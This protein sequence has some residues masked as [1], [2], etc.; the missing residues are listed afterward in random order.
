M[1]KSTP[2]DVPVE[3][4]FA[5]CNY[6]LVQIKKYKSAFPFLNPVDPKRDGVLNYFDIVKDPMDLSTVET[7]LASGVYRTSAEFHAHVNRIW[8]NSYTFNEKESLVHKLT[9]DMEKYYKSLL[10]TDS[11]K[12]SLKGEKS[13]KIRAEK[14]KS[15]NNDMVDERDERDE[16]KKAE[17][18]SS[19]DYVYDSIND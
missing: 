6:V 15:K 19:K 17:Y 12:K 14:D 4:E 7:N 2:A 1:R 18:F 5:H 10:N 13:L 16:R 8:S 11:Y 3:D 9:V